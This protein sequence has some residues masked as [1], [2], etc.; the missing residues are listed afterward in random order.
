[1]R[2]IYV[3]S[4]VDATGGTETTSGIYRIHTFTTSGTFQVTALIAAVPTVSTDVE[5]N[6]T[7]ISATLNGTVSSDGGASVAARG[8]AW[9][10]SNT[11]Q[12]A[13][14]TSTNG[15]G[16]GSFTNNVSGLI[17]GATYYYRAY[18]TNSA[19]TGYGTIENLVAGTDTTTVRSMKLFEGFTINLL[20]GGTVKLFQQA[21][22]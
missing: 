7:A 15:T 21:Y 14:G 2:I 17:A 8:F 10:T 4:E 12:D 19:G 20:E 16:T 13:F 1:V 6:V 18:A 22:Q 11:L 5:T 9:G 3:D